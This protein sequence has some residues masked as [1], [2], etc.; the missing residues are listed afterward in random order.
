MADAAL[1]RLLDGFDFSVALLDADGDI[2]AT[3]EAWTEFGQFNGLE[4]PPDSIGQNYLSVCE[5]AEDD[6]FARTA[7][8]GIRAVLDGERGSFRLEY[9]CHSP[10]EKR[11][12]LMYAGRIDLSDAAALVAHLN[13]TSRKVSE[14]TVQRRNQELETL[15]S[16]LSHD[17]RNPLSVASGWT[18]ILEDEDEHDE[19]ALEELR[20][21]LDR[22]EEI[23]EDALT[24]VRAGRELDERTEADLKALAESAWDNVRTQ[25]ATLIVEDSMTLRCVP[26]LLEN[27]FENLFRNSVEHGGIDV[28]IRVGTTEDGFYVE[29][30]GP[31]IPPEDRERIFEFGYTGSDGTGIG[32]AIVR[33]I[34]RAHGWEVS[35]ESA[36]D[37]G[38]RFVITTRPELP[39]NANGEPSVDGQ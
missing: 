8:S 38:A 4:G 34:V 12:F 32:L 25:Q 17:L 21:A 6:P 36:D 29:D 28:T 9:P 1:E 2:L 27:V 10:E 37:G 18:E 31:G 5:T 30:D 14:L 20:N 26:S 35:A 11:W 33:T 19:R 13:I 24:F 39:R 22:M 7:A 3:N 23:I 16:I 15:A